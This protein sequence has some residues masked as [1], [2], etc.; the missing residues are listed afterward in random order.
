MP[1]SFN[2]TLVIEN[3]ELND[4]NL[5]RLFDALPD[6]VPAQIA[7]LVTIG[8]PVDADTAE[9]AAFALVETIADL[10]PEARPCRLDQDLVSITDIA[11]RTGRTRES[12]RLLVDGKRGPGSFPTPVGTVG[13]GI[14]IWPWAVV[15]QWF[16]EFLVEEIDDPGVPPDVAA[17]VDASLAVCA[18]RPDHPHQQQI[19]ERA[20]RAG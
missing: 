14:R 18:H 2:V 7:G 16:A 12:V 3:L 15:V 19:P 8:S 11:G 17:V 9:S 20:A 6:A 5:D 4:D 1:K 13:D 10:F